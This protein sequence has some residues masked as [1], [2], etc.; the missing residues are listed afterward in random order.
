[1]TKFYQVNTTAF[2]LKLKLKSKSTKIIWY[3]TNIQKDQI[4]ILSKNTH[5]NIHELTI[6]SSSNTPELTSILKKLK[7][8]HSTIDLSNKNSYSL[9]PPKLIVI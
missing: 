2:N 4:T 3:I 5:K 8:P 1:M 9:N 7:Q 6:L